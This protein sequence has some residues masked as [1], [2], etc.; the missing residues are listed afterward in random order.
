MKRSSQ[1]ARSTPTRSSPTMAGSLQNSTKQH[2]TPSTVQHSGRGRVS[3]RP[4]GTLMERLQSPTKAGRILAA[5]QQRGETKEQAQRRKEHERERKREAARQQARAK[6]ERQ[7]AQLWL[8]LEHRSVTR[9][10]AAFRGRRGRAQAEAQDKARP[11]V[12]EAVR[13]AERKRIAALRATREAEARRELAEQARVRE[14]ALAFRAAMLQKLGE[15]SSQA[16]AGRA[17]GASEQ[18]A[19][20]ALAA[21]AQTP[22]NDAALLAEFRAIEAALSETS[23]L[24]AESRGNGRCAVRA[25]L[26]VLRD[27]YSSNYCVE[28]QLKVVRPRVRLQT[29]VT[30]SGR[31]AASLTVEVVEARPARPAR[32]T[33]GWA[34]VQKW[35]ASRLDAHQKEAIIALFRPK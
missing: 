19:A 28:L 27:G 23:A 21:V 6:V 11:G 22:P 35:T 5:Q 10:Q 18:A 25:R 12:R 2:G 7:Q 24:E 16:E 26:N 29:T 30:A 15:G 33:S 32:E 9:L 8:A 3:D 17:P 31:V 4:S 13:E 34:A 20:A 14:V 1:S